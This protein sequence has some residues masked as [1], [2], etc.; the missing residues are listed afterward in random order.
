MQ[1]ISQLLHSPKRSLKRF[2][3][4]SVN[5]FVDRASFFRTQ[6]ISVTGTLYFCR[7]WRSILCTF[8]A[9]SS[10]QIQIQRLRFALERSN[11][12][13]ALVIAIHCPIILVFYQYFGGHN[14]LSYIPRFYKIRGWK[15]LPIVMYGKINSA[16][17]RERK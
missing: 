6:F 10:H 11:I 8:L 15:S 12:L 3:E 14:T 13:F 5:R 1:F 9:K 17:T 4:R 7:I 16:I 2:G